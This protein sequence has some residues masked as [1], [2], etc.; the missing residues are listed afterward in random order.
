MVL[1]QATPAAIPTRTRP[2]PSIPTRVARTAGNGVGA[3]AA[4][5]ETEV[6]GIGGDLRID[7][8]DTASPTVLRLV[9]ELDTVTAPRLRQELVALLDAGETRVVVDLASMTFV[10]STGLGALVGGLKRFRAVS[11]DLVL[12]S[13]TPSAAKA[14]EITG[15]T[16]VFTIENSGADPA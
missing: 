16:S 8:L 2:A 4:R 5:P 1:S 7:L 13:P 9:G 10:D 6:A 12:R 11:G 14:L 3:G 15:L